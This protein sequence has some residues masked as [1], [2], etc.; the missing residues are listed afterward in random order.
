MD[1]GNAMQIICNE[2]VGRGF[3]L[4]QVNKIIVTFGGP[5]LII[6]FIKSTYD[7]Y[8]SLKEAA[9]VAGQTGLLASLVGFQGVPF[10]H[11]AVFSAR[12]MA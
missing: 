6:C 3:L 5:L 10:R 8:D 2:P 1:R 12:C 9:E 7:H 11:L 4:V